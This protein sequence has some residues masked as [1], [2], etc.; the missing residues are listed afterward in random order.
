MRSLIVTVF[1][2]VTSSF[3][4][5]AS[6]I[7]KLIIDGELIQAADSLSSVS[8]ALTRDG[9]LLFYAGLLEP[10]GEKAIMFMQAALQASVAPIHREQIYLRLAQYYHINRD[11]NNLG[12][13]VTEYLSR[14]ET[15]KYRDEML[16]FSILMDDLQSQYESALRQLD[17]Y[18]LSYSDGDA[19]QWGQLDKARVLLN[20]GKKIGAVKILKKLIRQKSGV[21]VPSG[22]YLLTLGAIAEGRTD[23]AVFYYSLLKESF[24]SAIGVDALLDRMSYVSPGGA[25]DKTANELTGTYYSVRLGVFS[26]KENAD[27]MVVAFQRYGKKVEALNKIISDKKYYV[28]YIGRFPDYESAS[29]F[30]ETLQA[31]NNQVYQVVAR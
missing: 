4:S 16:R 17:H 6:D 3:A 7:Y 10:N 15:G 20:H 24:P 25:G 22:M 21:G 12:N 5:A 1:L 2:L 29:R 14:W 30:K 8:T 31:E 9:D 23:D 26:V 18:S 11:M 28:V 13:I 27:N 19:G